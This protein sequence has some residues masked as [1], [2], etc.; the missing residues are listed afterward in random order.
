MPPGREHS[1]LGE[2]ALYGWSPVLRG[3]IRLLHE[4]Q[5]K[6]YFLHWSA[7]T[8]GRTYFGHSRLVILKRDMQKCA[9]SF[10]TR[11][12]GRD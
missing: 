10:K 5:I 8:G 12:D 11:K 2:A 7:G 4:I 3:C 9:R 6:L 1:Q